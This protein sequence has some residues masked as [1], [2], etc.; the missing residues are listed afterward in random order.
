MLW[1]DLPACYVQLPQRPK[2]AARARAVG[3]ILSPDG[4]G[5]ASDWGEIEGDHGMCQGHI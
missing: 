5:D 3:R 1:R 4:G 2:A